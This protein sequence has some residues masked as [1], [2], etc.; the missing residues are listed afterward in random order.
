MKITITGGTGFIGTNLCQRLISLGHEVISIDNYSSGKKSN[1]I[2]NVKYINSDCRHISKLVDD[3]DLVFHLGEYSKITPSFK[4]TQTIID[5]NM[6][7][8]AKVIEYCKNKNIKIVYAGSSTKYSE[9]GANASPYA[10][11][12][13]KNTELIKNYG[14]WFGLQY[15]ICYFYNNYGP[16]QDTCNDG[17]E[18]VISIFE[19]QK[20]KGTPLTI[21][22]P[23]T[24]RRNFTYV[25]DTVEG[26][27][28]SAFKNKNDE[29]QLSSNE[30]YNMF[31][32]A[33]LFNHEYELIPERPGD[34]IISSIDYIDTYKKLNWA[35]KYKLKDWI[36]RNEN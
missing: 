27:I 10:F 36:T 8:T 18:T 25:G 1:H 19:K 11:S 6:Y 29:Y 12:K 14:K 16:Y 24:Q 20:I 3:V 13:A 15:S 17:W 26:L 30:S 7:S 33:K 35:P 31:E 21:V 5:T 32:L 28:A 34:R 22:K 2:P 23:G 9:D 4:D